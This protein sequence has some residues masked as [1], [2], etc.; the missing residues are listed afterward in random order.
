MKVKTIL[1]Y[2]LA[3]S[4][5]SIAQGKQPLDT[6]KEEYDFLTWFFTESENRRFE[7]NQPTK[8][9]YKEGI[10]LNELK[11]IKERFK[12]ALYDVKCPLKDGTLILSSQELD[13]INRALDNMANRTLWPDS[14]FSKS[15]LIRKD[16]SNLP[17]KNKS[18]FDQ[19]NSE[20][21]YVMA[22]P[23]FLRNS[24]I[25]IFYC[26]YAS[27]HFRLM[28]FKKVNNQWQDWLV[29]FNHIA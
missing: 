18:A 28:V 22:K 7:A 6:T 2:L 26:A 20:S 16:R 11:T 27:S 13:S 23:I 4:N 19:P 1:I 9:F 25:C 3:F 5:L 15:K 14:L 29:L 17:Y 8:V 10:S 24:T 12:G 21:Q